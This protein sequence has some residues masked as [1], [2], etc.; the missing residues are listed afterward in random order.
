[1]LR[2]IGAKVNVRDAKHG[3]WFFSSERMLQAKKRKPLP[4]YFFCNAEIMGNGGP[5]TTQR[6]LYRTQWDQDTTRDIL[7]D[8]IV[9]NPGASDGIGILNKT[10]RDLSKCES[11]KPFM[12]IA[13]NENIGVPYGS[14]ARKTEGSLSRK[15]RTNQA[16]TFLTGTACSV[17]GYPADASTNAIMPPSL[18]Y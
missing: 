1:M 10:G 18:L 12:L 16:T 4:S 17:S 13:K 9:E 11:A 5:D 3:S 7:Q 15:I 8:Y 2:Q 14:C 6:L